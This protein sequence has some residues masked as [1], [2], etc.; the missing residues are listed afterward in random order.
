MSKRRGREV[1]E[2]RPEE[3]TPE[4]R[5]LKRRRDRV[6]R[7]AGR[8]SSSRNPWRRGLVIGVPV[9]VIAVVAIYL[10]VSNL[11][12][13]CI[14]LVPVPTSS[15]VPAY[16]PAGTTNFG[17]TWCP[18]ATE[19]YGTAPLLT[20]TINGTVV[21]LPAAIGRNN[22]FPGGY[23][24]D[25]PI[26]TE[27]AA[28]GFTPNTINILSDWNYQYNLSTFFNVWSESYSNVF[29]SSAHPSQPIIYQPDDI[30]G[31]RTNATD[32]VRL[33][34]DNQLSSKG[35]L[36]EISTLDNTVPPYPSCLAK[37][38]GTGHTIA[39]TF[40]STATTSFGPASIPPL[41]ATGLANPYADGLLFFG[42][43][44]HYGFL[45]PFLQE[46]AKVAHFSSPWLALR[47]LL[48]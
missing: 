16:P 5:R 23:E 18:S 37:L 44:P 1:E 11:P 27:P 43:L 21:N 13:P 42:P 28:F 33:W 17:G 46:S 24:C 45:T 39:I 7:K 22:S 15:G 48:G 34:V 3:L 14:T 20:I 6:R 10:V 29:V 40:S 38:Y 32:V 26:R 19:V 36:L 30:L 2:A 9:G 4:D 35:P 41:D 8:D 47:G 31:F 12:T 25:L